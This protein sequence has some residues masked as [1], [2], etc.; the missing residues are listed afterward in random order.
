MMLRPGI[1]CGS[2]PRVNGGQMLG[3]SPRLKHMADRERAAT[4]RWHEPRIPH[5]ASC[6]FHHGGIRP[7]HRPTFLQ[8]DAQSRKMDGHRV[9]GLWCIHARVLHRIRIHGHAMQRPV[10][11]VLILPGQHVAIRLPAPWR[12]QHI[13]MG[14]PV[15]FRKLFPATATLHAFLLQSARKALARLTISFRAGRFSDRA[16]RRGVPGSTKRRLQLP[17]RSPS[18]RQTSPDR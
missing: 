3:R 5:F 10:V 12:G 17:G 6:N 18:W 11:P 16:P 13:L 9:S 15:G 14:R 7:L 4:F 1:P 2:R 8:H